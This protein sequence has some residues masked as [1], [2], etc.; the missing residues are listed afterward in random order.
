M[1]KF[2]KHILTNDAMPVESVFAV[3]MSLDVTRNLTLLRKV[4][5]CV[6]CLKEVS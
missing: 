2:F 3:K 4:F 6:T 1:L 5:N